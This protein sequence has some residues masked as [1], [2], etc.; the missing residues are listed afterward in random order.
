MKQEP[1]SDPARQAREFASFVV[2]LDDEDISVVLWDH[3][4]VN[5]VEL[6]ASHSDEPNACDALQR[7]LRAVA[8]RAH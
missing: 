6:L 4:F 2:A 8:A 7:L 1:Q 3:A 5:H